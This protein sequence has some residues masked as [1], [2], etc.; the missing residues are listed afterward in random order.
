M[1][2]PHRHAAP[3]RPHA[4]AWSSALPSPLLET[5]P[6]PPPPPLSSPTTAAHSLRPP[7]LTGTHL[8]APDAVATAPHMIGISCSKQLSHHPQ[9]IRSQAHKIHPKAHCRECVRQANPASHGHESQP[10]SPECSLRVVAATTLLCVVGATAPAV[11][12]HLSACLWRPD[13]SACCLSAVLALLG[14]PQALRVIHLGNGIGCRD[15]TKPQDEYRG[16]RERWHVRILVRLRAVRRRVVRPAIAVLR[17]RI[18]APQHGRY[19]KLCW[20]SGDCAY[21][22]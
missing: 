22:C 9:T 12:V 14:G 18:R 10:R 4:P 7:W 8:D 11:L 5:L 20:Y 2:R 6:P 3:G 19:A 17:P 13:L 1:D 15:R 16:I 21:G